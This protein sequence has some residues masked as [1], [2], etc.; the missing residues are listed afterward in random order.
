ML[1][2]SVLR[3]RALPTEGPGPAAWVGDVRLRRMRLYHSGP[4]ASLRR[5]AGARCWA[6]CAEA[7][8]RIT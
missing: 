8:V 4:P 3:H 2:G 1:T 6:R 5:A 7:D